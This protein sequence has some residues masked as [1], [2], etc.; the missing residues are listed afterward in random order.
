METYATY[1]RL[2][3]LHRDILFPMVYKK[4]TW[5]HVAEVDFEIKKKD[6]T[7][8]LT[9][10]TFWVTHD[11]NN[12]EGCFQILFT[13]NDFPP[14]TELS[15]NTVR[16][17]GMAKE[18]GLFVDPEIEAIKKA[19]SGAFKM[20]FTC[21]ENIE[22]IAMENNKGGEFSKIFVNKDGDLVTAHNKKGRKKRR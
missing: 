12:V 9:S 17:E 6:N 8:Y 11:R 15:R 7:L 20:G 4:I 5:E 14:P 3:E 10:S 21:H 19:D 1:C 22:K 16:I 18:F 13:D 2:K